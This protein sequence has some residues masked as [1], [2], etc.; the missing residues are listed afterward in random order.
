VTTA[1]ADDRIRRTHQLV[2][3]RRD[4]IE[5]LMDDEEPRP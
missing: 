5:R 3:A 1:F 4:R 2:K